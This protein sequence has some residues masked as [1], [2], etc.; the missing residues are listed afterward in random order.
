M[1]KYLIKQEKFN[2]E[3]HN[4]VAIRKT[5]EEAVNLVRYLAD[6]DPGN[7]Y[8]HHSDTEPRSDTR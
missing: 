2:G 3:P 8:F 5:K 4:L 7:I 1:T 6:I